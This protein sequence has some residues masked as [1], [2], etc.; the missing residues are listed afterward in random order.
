MK[1]KFG[2]QKQ[3]ILYKSK[4]HNKKH[5]FLLEQNNLEQKNRI[6]EKTVKPIKIRNPGIDIIRILDMFTIIIHHILLNAGFLKKYKQY[7]K[8]LYIIFS[9]THWHN[10]CFIF[11]SGFIGYKTTKYSNLIYIWCWTFFYYISIKIYY[12][13]FKSNTYKESI[14]Y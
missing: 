1:K 2:K 7:K 6:P 4:K 5:Q 14:N 3:K 8:T 10:C 13:K 11:I 9:A 12:I